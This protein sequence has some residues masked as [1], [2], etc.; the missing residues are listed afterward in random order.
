MQLYVGKA[1]LPP[2]RAAL[3]QDVQD[4]SVNML[5]A[6][7]AAM[8]TR[9][10]RAKT[11]VTEMAGGCLAYSG[12]DV[13]LTRAIGIGTAGKVSERDLD[14]VEQFFKQRNSAV[15]IVIS[16]RT[17]SDVQPM[18]TSR[19]YKSANFMENWWLP[20]HGLG[21]KSLSPA[22]EITPVASHEIETWV[23]TVAAG[24]EEEQSTIDENTLCP[25]TL[26]TFYCLGFSRGAQPFLARVGGEVA[27]GGVLHVSDHKAHLR[28][29]S[30]R[31]KFRGLGVQTALLT[32]RLQA[33]IEA[34]CKIAFSSTDRR[35]PSARNLTRF[36]LT[37]FSV[38]FQMSV[39]N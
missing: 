11:C 21:M 10:S 25:R 27:G 5:K 16:E 19:G 6:A 17:H 15:R 35:G 38:S 7:T 22:V 36:G 28:T 34:G 39:P 1:T 31:F 29:T 32:T 20:L 23:R 18:L 12:P 2:N 8:S 4:M 24:F 13:P 30:C 3:L 37:P 33:A 14:A 9:N 26:D